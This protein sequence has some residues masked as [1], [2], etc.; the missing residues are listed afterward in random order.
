MIHFNWGELFLKEEVHL[1]S[2][3]VG[4]VIIGG[5]IFWSFLKTPSGNEPARQLS[6]Q[7]VLEF[8]ISF[9][10]GVCDSVI[11]P[12]GRTMVPI[13][14]SIFFI[15]WIQN[16]F[17]L[18]PG[19]TAATDN[20]NSTLA[21]GVC[22]FGLYNYYGIKQHGFSYIRHFLGPVLLIAPFMFILEVI[23]HFMRP[24]SLALRLYGNMMGD[25]TV[26]SSFVDMVPIGVP[27][28]FYFVGLFVCTIQAFVFTMLSM[29][30]FS[31][32]ISDDH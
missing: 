20:L 2:A 10:V 1:F 7:A 4:F 8:F 30:Y 15:I 22:S 32:A 26:L 13:F 19:F 23:T 11:G 24:V 6:L 25:H 3:L 5:L 27:V 9:I 14:G 16:L 12:K 28:I 18:I 31:M 29:I 17:T 21:F